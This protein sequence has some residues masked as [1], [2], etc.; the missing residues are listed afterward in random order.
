MN[1][2]V[3]KGRQLLRQRYRLKQERCRCR[4]RPASKEH[5]GTAPLFPKLTS[6]PVNLAKECQQR[7][8]AEQRRSHVP[9]SVSALSATE[10]SRTTCKSVLAV[11]LQ[12]PNCQERLTCLVLLETQARGRLS[13]LHLLPP[14]FV[15]HGGTSLAARRC[16]GLEGAFRRL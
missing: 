14:E 1:L 12:A 11:D 3:S 16:G 5:D 2:C 9:T 4:K 10:S 7:P 8:S 6:H 13:M 15:D